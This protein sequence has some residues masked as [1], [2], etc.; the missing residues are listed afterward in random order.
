[1]DA[2]PIEGHFKPDLN[3]TPG[4]DLYR[5]LYLSALAVDYNLKRSGLGGILMSSIEKY[6][7]EELEVERVEEDGKRKMACW[8]MDH[9]GRANELFYLKNGYKE[10]ERRHITHRPWNSLKDFWWIKMEKEFT[11][12]PA[13]NS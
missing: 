4:K 9:T 13:K 7:S 10:V 2:Q 6:V 8:V 5:Q 3:N 12:R 1:M 11:V